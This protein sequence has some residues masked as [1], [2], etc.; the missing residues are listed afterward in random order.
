MKRS[1]VVG[2]DATP[3]SITALRRAGEIAQIAD[4]VLVVVYV[5]NSSPW[6]ALSPLS[7]GS[8]VQNL[9]EIEDEVR[10]VAAEVLEDLPVSSD[11]LVR[12]G[13][14]VRELIAAADDRK[15]L[16]IVVG[17]R[18][19]NAAVSAVLGSVATGLV[20]HFRG[21]V[22]VVRSDQDSEWIASEEARDRWRRELATDAI[23]G[24][25]LP[26]G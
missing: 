7:A 14:P 3:D 20:H 26:S 9:D 16:C 2:V 25:A 21:S 4:L 13:D 23:Y 5:R 19:H 8:V 6:A 24:E 12:T 10:Q 17:G 22:L 15:A 18:P 1:L 11:L